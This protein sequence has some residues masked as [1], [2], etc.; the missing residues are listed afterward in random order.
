[1][2]L[3]LL[4]SFFVFSGLITVPIHAQTDVETYTGTGTAV[5]DLPGVPNGGGVD[6][7]VDFIVTSLDFAPGAVIF[8]GTPVDFDGTEADFLATSYDSDVGVPVNSGPATVDVTHDGSVSGAALNSTFSGNGTSVDLGPGFS[9][10]VA[11]VLVGSDY[12][13]A[14]TTSNWNSTVIPELNGVS[15]SST[16]DNDILAVDAIG[17]I[18]DMS[19]TGT[20]TAFSAVP[21]LGEWG[22]IVLTVGLI[23]MALMIL[24]RRQAETPAAA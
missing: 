11:D 19:Y 13:S 3:L 10:G 15:V 20:L 12:A 7:D 14:V 4:L 2:R 6:F 17:G 22:L 21:T 23:G 16:A 1:M 24:R 8:E 18:I 9:M 5:I